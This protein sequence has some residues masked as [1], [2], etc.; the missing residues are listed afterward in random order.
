MK[1]HKK[2]EFFNKKAR[3]DYKIDDSV[4]TGIVLTSEEIKAIRAGKVDMSS[5]YAKI[6]NGEIFWLGGSINAESG[7]RQRTRKLLLHKEQI[8]KLFGKT[9]EKGLALIPLKL[10]LTRGKAKIELG[11]GRGMKK[12]EKREVL[13]KKDTQRDIEI[14]LKNTKS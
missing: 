7:D 11:L 4:E 3:F 1:K 9:Q 2:I 5:S 12:Y 13:K 6:I 14:S 10:Y 8:Q